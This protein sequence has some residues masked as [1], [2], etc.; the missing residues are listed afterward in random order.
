MRP[1]H[2][3]LLAVLT[4]A[5]I[6]V[7]AFLTVSHFGMRDW[8]NPPMPDTATRLITPTEAAG[9]M[10]DRG[11]DDGDVVVTVP[12]SGD[13][14]SDRA[15]RRAQRAQASTRRA[16]RRSDR[17]GHR[18]GSRSGERRSGN[19]GGDDR[20][21]ADEAGGAAP[22]SATPPAQGSTTTAPAGAAGTSAGED[23]QARPDQTPPPAAEPPVTLDPIVPNL[24][25]GGSGDDESAGD[26]GARPRDGRGPGRGLVGNLLDQ[27]P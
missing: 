16:P 1:L 24:P 20:R 27:L 4:A 22:D 2:A 3:I 8:P 19:R 11:G 6:G 12:D 25:V 23:S 13:G 10:S 18:A 21:S 9:R 14:E 5:V 7:S 26:E 15:D 17:R